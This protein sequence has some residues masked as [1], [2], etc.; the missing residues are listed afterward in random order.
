M[1][2]PT[3]VVDLG[4]LTKPADTLIK[5][6]SNAIGGVFAPYQI[7]RLAKAEA[8]AQLLKAQGDVRVTDLQRR[9]VRRW[10]A[11]EGHRQNNIEGITAKALPRL[12]EDADAGLVEDDWFV[13]FFDKSRIVSDEQM[14]DLWARVLSGEANA[15]GSFSRRTVNAL[16]DLDRADAELFT[17]L[18]GFVWHSGG[19]PIPL[20]FDS[21]ATIYTSRR[22]HFA[23]LSHLEDVGLVKFNNLTGF[24]VQGIGK[25]CQLYYYGRG[26]VLEM[27]K[28]ENNP[29]EVGS[30]L[31][32]KVGWELMQVCEG[33]RVDGFWE[34]V[35]DR[36][37]QYLPS[38]RAE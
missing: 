21:E 4:S 12:T 36:W 23:S 6:I 2:L 7:K 13:N 25:K 22:I 27:P 26:L 14:Q 33:R 20:V 19:R 9:A 29:L 34:Y 35:S 8:E 17:D 24:I 38:S 28:D 1:A 37:R 11:E 18:A 3:P 5:K 31:L 30:V 15:P 32:T 16:A 10:I